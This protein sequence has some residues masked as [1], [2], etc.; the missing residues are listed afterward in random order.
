[1]RRILAALSLTLSL[2]ACSGG[3]DFVAP[4]KVSRQVIMDALTDIPLRALV[5]AKTIQ[6]TRQTQDAVEFTIDATKSSQSSVFLITLSPGEKGRIDIAVTIDVPAI[7]M[8]GNQYLSEAKV[9]QHFRENLDDLI[10]ALEAGQS[11]EGAVRELATI[12]DAVTYVTAP[13]SAEA[14]AASAAAAEFDW[15]SGNASE[16]GGS[17]SGED[18]MAADDVPSEDAGEPAE[19]GEETAEDL[20]LIHI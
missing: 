8:G 5:G 14:A 12:M 3:A 17:F 9:E 18:D 2:A 6:I 11:G 10:A 7:S 1:M 19:S 4:A 16:D 20:S 13:E 15:V